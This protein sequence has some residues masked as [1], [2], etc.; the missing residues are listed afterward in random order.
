M[1][2]AMRRMTTATLAAANHLDERFVKHSQV[3][4]VLG[5]LLA[6]GVAVGGIFFYAST[7]KQDQASLRQ[8]ISLKE[9]SLRQEISLKEFSLKQEQASLRQEAGLREV[10]ML[11][12]EERSARLAREK[13]CSR[14][15]RV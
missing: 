6:T 15:F 7:L 10:K 9:A 8:E 12:E 5:L 4:P 3:I 13:A 14:W 2:S 1:R 11:V